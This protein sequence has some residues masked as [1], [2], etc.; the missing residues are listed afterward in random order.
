MRRGMDPADL[1]GRRSFWTAAAGHRIRLAIV[2]LNIRVGIEIGE[3]RK[4]AEIRNRA[5]PAASLI[6]IRALAS[7]GPRND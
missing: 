6:R 2:D 4:R 1:L 3:K 7:D 5:S